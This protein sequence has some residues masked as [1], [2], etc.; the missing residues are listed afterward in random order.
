[1]A[2]VTPASRAIAF[3]DV[4][5]I[6]AGEEVQGDVQQLFAAGGNALAAARTSGAAGFRIVFSAGTVT[7]SLDLIHNLP[8]Y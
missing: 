5:A 4:L 8:E 2:G 6:P 7:L 1:M 3:N